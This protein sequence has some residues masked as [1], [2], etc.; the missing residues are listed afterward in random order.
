[1]RRPRHRA[2][3]T[4]LVGLLAL[5][6]GCSRSNFGLPQV[7]LAVDS[8]DG[9]YR[10][11]VRNHISL[12]PPRQSLWLEQVGGGRRWLRNL[13]ED[14]E[15]CDQA[16]WTPDGRHVAFVVQGLEVLLYSV[17]D[18]DLVQRT[19]L[20]PRTLGTPS[21]RAFDLRLSEDGSVLTFRLCSPRGDTCAETSRVALAAPSDLG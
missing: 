8:P 10:A 9:G 7:A 16:I 14:Q 13:A 2:G 6:G 5:T 1:M 18:G 20:A 4:L 17:P 11:T 21:L 15:G 19:E 3:W 12:D